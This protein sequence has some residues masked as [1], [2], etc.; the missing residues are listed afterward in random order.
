MTA[1]DKEL[2]QHPR[3]ITDD[4]LQGLAVSLKKF[5]CVEPIIV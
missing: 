1:E 5:G 4:A 2:F 3:T